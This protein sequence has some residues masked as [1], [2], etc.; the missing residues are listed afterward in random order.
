MTEFIDGGSLRDWNNAAEQSWREIV[1]LLIGVADGL[2]AAHDA[3]ILHRDIK[4][5]NILVMKSGYAKLADFGLAKLAEEPEGSDATKT[6]TEQRTQTGMVL[7][8]VAY[9][10]PEQA[11]GKELDYSA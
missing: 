11:Q 8:T 7:G 1:E 2:A 5:G 4:P 9:M 10:S 6:V 3:K